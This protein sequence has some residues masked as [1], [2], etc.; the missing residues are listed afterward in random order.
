MPARDR[1]VRHVAFLVAVAACVLAPLA[2]LVV[3]ALR[4]DARDLA[5]SHRLRAAEALLRHRAAARRRGASRRGHRHRHGLAGHGAIDFPAATRC[6]GCCRCRSRSRPT[7]S[8]TSMWTCSTPSA[9]CRRRCARSSAGDSAADY[10][11]PNIRSLPGAI[12]V[13]GIVLYPYVY[14]AARAMFQ[15]Q[16]AQFVEAAR[17][18][19]ATASAGAAVA[20]PLARPALAVGLSLVS[21]ETLNDIGASEYL[22]VQTLTL[23]IFTTWLNRGSLP[24]AAQIACVMLV[25]VAG[26]DRARALRPPASAISVSPPR[27]ARA[28]DPADGATPGRGFAVCALPV[29]LGFL[30]SRRLSRCSEVSRADY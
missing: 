6:P 25:V 7:S 28:A 8:L 29:L 5:A 21:L 14:L 1:L 15:T 23:S 16:S 27:R 4:G 17:T 12:F 3:I 30:F 20:L 22:G 10:W 13:I 11:F 26:A 24:G 18:L 19:G 9:R 2:S